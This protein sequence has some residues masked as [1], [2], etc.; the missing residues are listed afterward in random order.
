[1]R[2]HEDSCD[3]RTTVS[4]NEDSSD[5]FSRVRTKRPQR[6]PSKIYKKVAPP[7]QDIAPFFIVAPGRWHV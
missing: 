4:S 5:G 6:A 1:M 7:T 2:I 3:M